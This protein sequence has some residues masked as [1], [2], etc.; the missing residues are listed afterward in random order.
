MSRVGIIVGEIPVLLSAPHSRM[1]VRNGSQK[2]PE[3]RTDEIV[4]ECAIIRTT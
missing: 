1:H 4:I 2:M 3:C